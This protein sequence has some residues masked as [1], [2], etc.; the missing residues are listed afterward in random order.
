M[1]TKEEIAGADGG[2]AK[3]IAIEDFVLAEEIDPVYY[4]R[5]YY[6]GAGKD[7]EAR[8]GCCWRRWRRASASDRA[9]HLPQ[10]R[11]ARRARPLDDGVLALHTMRFGD[12]VVSGTDP[13][14]RARRRSRPSARS[15]WRRTCVDSLHGPF[16]PEAYEDTYRD[17]VMKLIK[18]KASGKEIELPEDVPEDDAHRTC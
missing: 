6:L 16:E 4:D 15:T 3:V 8:T 17:S 5:T 12:E 9:L 11:A 2:A 18:R 13:T 14:S 10:Q 7:G 1:L